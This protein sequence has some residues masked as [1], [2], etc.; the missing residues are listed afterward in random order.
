MRHRDCAL[1]FIFLLIA[2][3]YSHA[4]H[5]ETC[6]ASVGQMTLNTQNLTYLPTL[7]VNSQ[8]TNQMADNGNGIHF[9]CDLQ[10]P[11][12]NWKRIVY[13]QKD[14]TGAGT[15]INGHHVFASKLNGVSYSAGFQ[16]NGGP[17]RY[18]GDSTAPAGGESV[19]VCDSDE[20][21]DLLGEREPIVKM[22]ITFY[23]TGEVTMSGG[24]HANVE[25]QPH[26]GELYIEDRTASGP[27]VK[28]NPVS[29]DLA[30]LNVDIGASGSCQV[31]TSSIQ[32]NLGSVNRA[33]FKGKGL[34]AGSAR[35][36]DIP[37]YCSAPSDVRVGFFGIMAASDSHDTLALTKSSDMA[38]GVGVKLTYGN[39]AASAPSP[40][41]S[42]KINQ[43][44]NLPILKH[45]TAANAGNAE[46]VN[47]SAQYVQTEGSV[48][49]GEANSIVTFAL[50][51]N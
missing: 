41:T 4:S 18:I 47:F 22:Y 29:I 37:V 33:E 51:Y 7:P 25:S 2:G 23:K 48:T 38:T 35:S 45:V 44:T 6:M 40:G 14:T 1:F 46:N 12:A 9:T 5:A 43:A 20:L 3:F 49:A 15:V 19:T 32:V 26:F 21:P 8:M 10:A 31:S 13:Q 50:V 36:F 39:N 11:L 34:T 16:C 24:N 30:A 28:S 27:S 17:I 42:V